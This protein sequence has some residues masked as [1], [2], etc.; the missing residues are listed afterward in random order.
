[1]GPKLKSVDNLHGHFTKNQLAD[2]RQVQDNLNN[3][4]SP[5]TDKIPPELRGY[6]RKEWKR[7]IPL[8]R[9][10]TPA[11]ELDRGQLINYC[12]LAQT[13]NTCQK[14][15][16]KDGLCVKNT[17]GVKKA[18]PYFNMQDKAIKNMRGIANDMGMTISSRARVENNKIK[19]EE[20][21][22]PFAAVLGDE[23]G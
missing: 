3:N 22:D 8:L 2:R 23:A 15:I 11:S 18:N 14:Y 10:Q 9:S 5:L 7:I 20:Q 1:M 16:L 13:V 21:L 19:T 4:Y 17:E 6:A 12:L